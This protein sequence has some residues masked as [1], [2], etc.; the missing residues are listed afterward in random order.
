M[1]ISNCKLKIIQ[2]ISSKTLFFLLTTGIILTLNLTPLIIQFN[3][4][5]KGRT[6]ALIHNNVQDFYFYQALMNEGA[7]GAALTYDPYTSE[8]HQP[9]I[10]FSYFL[11]LG[12]LSKLLGLPFAITYHLTRISLSIL[13]LFFIFY[14][15]FFISLP[16]PRL[17]YLFFLFAAPFMHTINDYGMLRSVPFMNWWNGID[18]IRRA[19]FLPHHMLG[20]LLLVI[21]IMLIFKYINPLTNTVQ[22]HHLS[23]IIYHN[24][25]LLLIILSAAMAFVHTPSLLVLLLVLPFS[26]SIYFVVNR[27]VATNPKSQIPNSKQYLNIQT[28]IPTKRSAWRDLSRMRESFSDKL[29]GPSTTL[30]MT[31]GV[32]LSGIWN[33]EFGISQFIGLLVYWFIGLVFLLMMVF[34]TKTGFPWSQYIDWEKKLQFPLNKE[35]IGA[36]GILFPFSILGAWQALKSRKFEYIFISCWLF[37]PFILIPLVPKIGLSNIRLIQGVPYLPLAILASIGI[38]NISRFMK[39]IVSH[40]FSFFNSQSSINFHFLKFK[41][42][43]YLIWIILGIFIIFTYPTILWSLKDQIR[44]YWPIYG[45]VYLDN[46]LFDAFKFINNNYPAKTITLCTFYCGNYLPAYTNTIS[47]IGHFGYTYNEEEKEKNVQRFFKGE[48][49]IDEAKTFLMSNKIA[50]IFQGPEEKPIYNRYLYPKILKQVYDKEEVTIYTL[51][52]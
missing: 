33:L 7:N 48:M 21:S 31:R 42:K 40:K 16:H 28:V 39:Y 19:A 23:K 49:S 18:P 25:L 38:S 15:L 51:N 46:R 4:S 45:N 2:L 3:H 27:L 12:K 37:V 22:R 43:N 24:K 36:L 44:E 30:G 41:I 34:Q 35:L 17:T 1:K 29:R 26:I 11:W 6:F 14:F 47:F 50:L 13:F 52:L 32:N 20:G 8:P 9:S 5:P 10:I